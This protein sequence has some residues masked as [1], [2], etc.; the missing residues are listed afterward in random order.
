MPEPLKSTVAIVTTPQA[1][2]SVRARLRAGGVRTDQIEV[3]PMRAEREV[4]VDRPGSIAIETRW[5]ALGASGG[6]LLGLLAVVGWTGAV[7][8]APTALGL[9]GGACLGALGGAVVSALWSTPAP[10]TR[11][12]VHP[13]WKVRVTGDASLVARARGLASRTGVALRRMATGAF[14]LPPPR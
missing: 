11:R 12:V 1:T 3:A 14:E 9:L 10:A 7:M 5:V 2:E 6:G 13:Y 8:L 4:S